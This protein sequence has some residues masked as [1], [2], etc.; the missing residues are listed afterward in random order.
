MHQQLNKKRVA[1][2]FVFNIFGCESRRSYLFCQLSCLNFQT[3]GMRKWKK[4][5]KCIHTLANIE[6]GRRNNKVSAK[7]GMK[8]RIRHGKC[9]F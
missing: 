8:E 7:L 3:G 9:N 6:T 2:P 5:R 4:Q 1:R